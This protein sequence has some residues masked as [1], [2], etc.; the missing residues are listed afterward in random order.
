MKN[1]FL[2]CSKHIQK[3]KL[4]TGS[5]CSKIL[6]WK[7]PILGWIKLNFDVVVLV[8]RENIFFGGLLR[9]HEDRWICGY[10]Q[11]IGFCVV[12]QAKA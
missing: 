7:R 1:G 8:E 10:Y 5:H 9:D 12:I 6:R 2:A 4:I 11:N 3:E